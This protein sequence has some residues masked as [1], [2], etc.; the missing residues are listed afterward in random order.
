[1]NTRT[2]ETELW[3]ETPTDAAPLGFDPQQLARDEQG[4]DELRAVFAADRADYVRKFGERDINK[5]CHAFY[6]PRGPGAGAFYQRPNGE[7]IVTNGIADSR[8]QGERFYRNREGCEYLGEVLNFCIAPARVAY[9]R[10]Q[11]ET[12][13]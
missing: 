5:I 13:S 10:G 11:K 3:R 1:M 6:S 9:L 2:I 12:A 8:E 4:Q 7:V